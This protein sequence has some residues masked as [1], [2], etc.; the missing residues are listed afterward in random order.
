MKQV[1][2]HHFGDFF[3]A[4]NQVFALIVNEVAA[5]TGGPFTL[6]VSGGDC[7]PVLHITAASSTQAVLDWTTAAVGYRLER[8]NNLP[9]VSNV[10]QSV[11]TVPIVVNS[12]FTVTNNVNN[13]NQF[14]RL[15]NP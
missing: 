12:R 11:P 15:V 13:T 8:T 5:S 4:A 3:A 14:Y 2:F 6:T 7:R 10:W 1:I 9:N